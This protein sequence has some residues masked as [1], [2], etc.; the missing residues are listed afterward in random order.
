M[1]TIYTKQTIRIIRK[2]TDK[3]EVET[4][5]KRL[6]KTERIFIFIHISENMK[7][8]NVQKSKGDFNFSDFKCEEQQENEN[9]YAKTKRTG[10]T[11]I[12]KEEFDAILKKAKQSLE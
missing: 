5:Y 4:Y 2:Q 6:S 11:L 3:K 12:G 8:F 1:E 9:G 10:E 7:V